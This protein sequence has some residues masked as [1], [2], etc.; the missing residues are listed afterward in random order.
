MILEKCGRLDDIFVRS[1]CCVCIN[2]L[3]GP[4]GRPYN[5]PPDPISGFRGGNEV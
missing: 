5:A 1:V 4:T 2:A 3:P